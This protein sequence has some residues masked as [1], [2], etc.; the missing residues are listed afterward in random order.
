MNPDRR[1]FGKK[2][3]GTQ[4]SAQLLN[5]TLKISNVAIVVNFPGRNI[6]N[7][8]QRT[9]SNDSIIGMLAAASISNTI[10]NVLSRKS[11]RAS[12]LLRGRRTTPPSPHD[13]TSVGSTWYLKVAYN[14]ATPAAP[15]WRDK[16][17][18]SSLRVMNRSGPSVD[19]SSYFTISP[20]DSRSWARS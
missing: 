18:G 15:S 12:H 13:K 8:L 14:S 11:R 2:T 5:L 9:V 1:L 6:A 10:I 7:G 17:L 19:R 16:R 3:D 20:D 4:I